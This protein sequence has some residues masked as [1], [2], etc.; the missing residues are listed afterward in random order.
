VGSVLAPDHSGL[1][2]SE[3]PV[4]YWFISSATALPI[5]VAIA[6]PRTTQPVL[7]TRTVSPVAPGV[8]RISLAEHGVRLAPGVAY[9]WSIAVV[10]DPDRRSRDILASGTIERIEPPA[11]LLETVAKAKREQVPF[12]YAE[13]GVW[14]DA[15]AAISELIER[16]PDDAALRQHRAALLAQVG[17]PEIAAEDVRT[18]R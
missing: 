14:Y 10:P 13:A 12:I 1:T 5:E 11:D 2:V 3:Q 8:H 16:V 17:L 9:R 6:D 7:E 15:L 4:L 18:E